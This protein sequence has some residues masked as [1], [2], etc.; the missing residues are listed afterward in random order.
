MEYVIIVEYVL[1]W[2]L[3]YFLKFQ[4][5]PR[6]IWYIFW[7][8]FYLSKDKYSQFFYKAYFDNMNLFQHD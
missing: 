3:S 7:P 4:D 8:L 5:A 2:V 1:F 6:L